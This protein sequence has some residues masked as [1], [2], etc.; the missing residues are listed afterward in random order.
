MQLKIIAMKGT[1]LIGL[2]G[3]CSGLLAQK[4]IYVLFDT[5]NSH[6]HYFVAGGKGKEV[7]VS[8]YYI[9]KTNIKDCSDVN[10]V[11]DYRLPQSVVTVRLDT[12][13]VIIK[14][15]WAAN[16][17]DTTLLRLFDKRFIYII[18]KDSVKDGRSK[19]YR[20]LYRPCEI[21]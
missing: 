12:L 15:E 17:Y 19:A 8:H 14:A 21:E 3:I 16:Q 20:V 9:D 7:R 1:M 5:K 10:F 13:K 18:P 4:P 6:A 11:H 2:L